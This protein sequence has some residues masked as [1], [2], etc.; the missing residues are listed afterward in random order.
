MEVKNKL[1]KTKW[2]KILI[3]KGAKEIWFILNR[4]CVSVGLWLLPA[5]CPSTLGVFAWDGLHA[6]YQWFK[7]DIEQ[8]K[9]LLSFCLWVYGESDLAGLPLTLVKCQHFDTWDAV[10]FL[11][12]Y[13]WKYL[14]LSLS[15]FCCLWC[16]WQMY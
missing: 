6:H 5:F 14:C 12:Q 13:F 15:S 10:M 16:W 4:C 11:L 1:M 7:E 2:A 3:I 9:L 8:I